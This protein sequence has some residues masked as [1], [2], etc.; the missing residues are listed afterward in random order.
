MAEEI[1]ESGKQKFE[2][3]WAVM[4]AELTPERAR[5]FDDE[6]AELERELQSVRKQLLS[7]EV[8]TV[9]VEALFNKEHYDEEVQT[10]S[11]RDWWRLLSEDNGKTR[12]D[13]AGKFYYQADW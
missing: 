8:E 1:A 2:A 11:L 7:G 12:R 6:K 10:G 3:E 9:K 13:K 5:E 4:S